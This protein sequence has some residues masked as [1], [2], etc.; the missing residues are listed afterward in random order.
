MGEIE[1]IEEKPLA[2]TEV[3]TMLEKIEKRDKELTARATK[4]KAYL[5][6]FV[7][8]KDKEAEEIKKKIDGLEISRL[9]PRHISK[10]I[11]LMPKDMGSL[12]AVFAG[13]NITLK[14]EDLN[15]ILECLK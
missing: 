12:R 5:D 13:E 14:Q 11:D 4:V 15:R 1:I 6:K 3:K 7:A 10:I 9:K 8:V 2:L